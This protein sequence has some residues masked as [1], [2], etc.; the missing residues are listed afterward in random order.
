MG[1]KLV[2]SLKQAGFTITKNPSAADIVFAHSGGCLLIPV[3][4]RAQ[5][6]MQVGTPY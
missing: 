6:I 4:N 2:T 1:R 3:D 5:L